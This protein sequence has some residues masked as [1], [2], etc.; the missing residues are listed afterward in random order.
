[1]AAV[2]NKPSPVAKTSAVGVPAARLAAVVDRGAKLS[3]EL[4]KS[5]ETSERAAI[6]SVGKFVITLEEALPREVTST[7]E[8]VKTITESGLE[9]A[10]QLIQTEYHL[11]RD[12]VD[13][14]ANVLRRHDV[15]RPV[16]V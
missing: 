15:A 3:D 10:D 13:S 2:A 8:L 4:L 9:T 16:V 14:A 6:E 7:S 12:V 11:L 5:F 1:M